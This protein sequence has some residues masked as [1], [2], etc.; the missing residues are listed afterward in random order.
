MTIK[1]TPLK[2]CYII[3]PKVFYDERGY[4]YEQ[5]NEQVFQAETKLNVKFVQDNVSESKFGVIRGLHYQQGM[6]SQAKLVTVLEG[7]VLDVAIDLRKNSPSFGKQ[8]SMILSSENKKQL[9]VP[10]GF[11]HGFS[12]LSKTARFFYKCDA[13]YNKESETGIKYND[14]TLN[15]DWQLKDGEIIVNDKDKHLPDFKSAIYF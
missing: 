12:V 4:F 3:E 11:A 15:I 2:D 5:F 10:K 13:Y 7:E 9:F 14:E 6:H 1:E 8:F